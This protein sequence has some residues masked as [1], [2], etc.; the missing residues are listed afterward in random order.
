MT[1]MDDLIELEPELQRKLSSAVQYHR[2]E[3][4]GAGQL[5]T[6]LSA[7]KAL[8]GDVVVVPREPTNDMIK[9]GLE[10]KWRPD[11]KF[12]PSVADIY[13]AMIGGQDE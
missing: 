12:G 2:L 4:I 1:A 5:Q 13:R 10:V 11:V 6:I 9:A 3:D 8:S 7:I